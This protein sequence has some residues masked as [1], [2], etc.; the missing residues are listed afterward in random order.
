MLT[1]YP[2]YRAGYVLVQICL[3]SRNQNGLAASPQIRAEIEAI[4]TRINGTYP[5]AYEPLA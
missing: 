3:G 4:A 2:R 5:G 1:D